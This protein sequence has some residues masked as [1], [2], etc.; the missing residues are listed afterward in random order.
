MPSSDIV[1]PGHSEESAA[2][3]AESDARECDLAA[4]TTDLDEQDA[5]AGMGKRCYACSSS[6]STACSPADNALG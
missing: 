6:S 5:V 4:R 2:S 3:S 1:G